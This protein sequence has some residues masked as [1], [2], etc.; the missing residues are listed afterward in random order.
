MNMSP[1]KSFPD[2]L[3]QQL[4][5]PEDAEP[6]KARDLKARNEDFGALRAFRRANGPLKE[7][8]DGKPIAEAEQVR[9]EDDKDIEKDDFD[10]MSDILAGTYNKTIETAI[11]SPGNQL[12]DNGPNQ[13][14]YRRFEGLNEVDNEHFNW[15]QK[16]IPITEKSVKEIM[17]D[18][19]AIEAKWPVSR[20]VPVL[21]ELFDEMSEDNEKKIKLGEIAQALG[22]QLT[23]FGKQ[24]GRLQKK[25]DNYIREQSRAK[26]VAINREVMGKIDTIEEQFNND[27]WGDNKNEEL[28]PVKA[29]KSILE[30]RQR[31]AEI[32]G[33]RNNQA[34]TEELA[35][36][37]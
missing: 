25:I 9:I 31:Y 8:F 21:G 5:N 15:L 32:R 20:E 29:E 7:T 34:E 33:Q 2:R 37:A 4:S 13:K 27:W 10:G 18:I 23:L 11:L 24:E 36:V 14:P 16:I 35:E 30:L 3:K 28:S 26:R 19:T 6:N 17:V 1:A 12:P 22:A